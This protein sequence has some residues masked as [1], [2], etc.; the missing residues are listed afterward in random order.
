MSEDVKEIPGKE[1]SASFKI[2][3]I[4]VVDT[5]YRSEYYKLRIKIQSEV[6]SQG[7]A[8]FEFMIPFNGLKTNAIIRDLKEMYELYKLSDNTK[9]S[10]GAKEE[11]LRLIAVLIWTLG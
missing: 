8:E 7:E 5:A 3:S 2:Q 6:L 9:I 10:E 11:I 4:T 1:L